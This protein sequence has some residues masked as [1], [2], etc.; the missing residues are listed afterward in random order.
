MMGG[1]DET[2]SPRQRA[3]K[4]GKMSPETSKNE[5]I[6]LHNVYIVQS[7]SPVVK[8]PLYQLQG[9]NRI[10]MY[11]DRNWGIKCQN[12]VVATGEYLGENHKYRV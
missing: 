4:F 7:Y 2:R 10:P 6:A 8:K 12:P 9:N 5:R 3:K 1:A 11:F